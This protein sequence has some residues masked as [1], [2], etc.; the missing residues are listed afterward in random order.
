[1]RW[2]LA[3]AAAV[4]AVP[5]VAAE[6]TPVIGVGIVS[7]D[8]KLVFL[9]AKDGGVEAVDLMFGKTQWTNKVVGQP[10]GASEKVLFTWAGDEKQANAFR[11]FAMDAATGKPLGKSELI[12]LPEWATTAKAAGRTFRTA[13][14]DDGD[15][16]IVVWQASAAKKDAEGVALV[17]FKTGKT[18]PTKNGK[19]RDAEFKAGPAGGFANTVGMYEFQRS[20]E[21]PAPKP[22]AAAVTKVTFIVLKG[23][24]EYWKRELPGN[25][26]P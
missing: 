5:A 9:P 3:L 12:E 11:V 15:T 8:E 22:G 23:K 21:V 7:A 16:A 6:P 20:E 4:F 1:M 26:A 13:V 24:K 25:P 2:L 19:P 18:T 14:V 17:D 10:A